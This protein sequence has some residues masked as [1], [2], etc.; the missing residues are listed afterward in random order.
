MS[1]IHFQSSIAIDINNKEEEEEEECGEQKDSLLERKISDALEE[2][3]ADIDRIESPAASSSSSSSSSSEDHEEEIVAT[4]VVTPTFDGRQEESDSTLIEETLDIPEPPSGFKDVEEFSLERK[5]S[6]LSSS[7]ST[8]TPIEPIINVRRSRSSSPVEIQDRERKP[9]SKDSGTELSSLSTAKVDRVEDR[10][11]AGSSSSQSSS[12]FDA[13][14]EEEEEEEPSR[15]YA[16]SRESRSLRPHRSAQPVMQFSIDSYNSRDSKEMPYAKKLSRTE[17]QSTQA[18]FAEGSVFSSSSSDS[19]ESAEAEI[20]L[21]ANER[22]E[23]EMA[24]QPNA[25]WQRY[26][27]SAPSM[28]LKGF[29]EDRRVSSPSK[30]VTSMVEVVEATMKESKRNPEK[31]VRSNLYA[32]Y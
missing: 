19:K 27:Q 28:S 1:R 6:I 13:E 11:L 2:S 22:K 32:V 10:F 8:E 9:E 29:E 12:D 30:S 7:S 17:S 26:E 16:S 3:F 15:I 21:T 4:T 24:L 14:E 23:V 25:P 20:I 31:S 18:H 5:E